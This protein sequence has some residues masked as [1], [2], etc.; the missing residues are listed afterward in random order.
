MQSILLHCN[1]LVLLVRI[2]FEFIR[3]WVKYF[4]FT[5]R[6]KHD[7]RKVIIVIVH[8]VYR[9][10]DSSGKRSWLIICDNW[11]NIEITRYDVAIIE[12]AYLMAS[13][14]KLWIIWNFCDDAQIIRLEI[15]EFIN[16]WENLHFLGYL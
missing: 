6:E 12:K 5:K 7:N 8:I 16:Q 14:E 15:F 9:L 11:W 2:N 10:F 3:D 4:Y 13:W 1:E